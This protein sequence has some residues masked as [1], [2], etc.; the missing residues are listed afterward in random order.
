MQLPAHA[1]N[2]LALFPHLART[3]AR[4]PRPCVGNPPHTTFPWLFPSPSWLRQDSARQPRIV[5]P[6]AFQSKA[7]FSAASAAA[8]SNC[9]V[10]AAEFPQWIRVNVVTTS[11]YIREGA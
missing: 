9:V 8:S 11:A 3:T 10:A 2:A 6:V 1:R 7:P 4:F 5:I